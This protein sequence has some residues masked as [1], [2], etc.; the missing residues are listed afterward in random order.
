MNSL[1]K[2]LGKK[3]LNKN[4]EFCNALIS[5]NR[6]NSS[7]SIENFDKTKNQ[8]SKLIVAPRGNLLSKL[9]SKLETPPMKEDEYIREKLKSRSQSQ[10]SIQSNNNLNYLNRLNSK[11]ENDKSINLESIDF[12][13]NYNSLSNKKK[14]VSSY[15][16]D[17]NKNEE[18][19][20]IDLKS[21]LDNYEPKSKNENNYRSKEQIKNRNFINDTQKNQFQGKLSD[22]QCKSENQTDEEIEIIETS[23]F[24]N[25]INIIKKGFPN[26][27][28]KED[29][30]KNSFENHKNVEAINLKTSGKNI[31]SNFG[32]FISFKD[33]F[34]EDDF[35]LENDISNEEKKITLTQSELKRIKITMLKIGSKISLL[36]NKLELRYIKNSLE[37]FKKNVF[38]D[39]NSKIK[40]FTD[41]N[42]IT[43][44]LILMNKKFIKDQ[45][46]YCNSKDKSQDNQNINNSNSKNLNSE[47]ISRNIP[48]DNKS[49]NDF[50]KIDQIP[51][52]YENENFIT[53]ENMGNDQIKNTYLNSFDKR[54]QNEYITSYSNTNP[55]DYESNIQNTVESKDTNLKN[56]NKKESNKNNEKILIQDQTNCSNIMNKNVKISDGD[57][58]NDPE[59]LKFVISELNNAMDRLLAKINH[60]NNQIA[61]KERIIEYQKRNLLVL[62]ERN[63]LQDEIKFEL[64]VLNRN[65]K[66]LDNPIYLTNTNFENNLRLINDRYKN[67]NLKI[68]IVYV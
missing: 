64:E 52:D 48:F 42:S 27:E 35:N 67:L 12:K 8:S 66:N 20:S 21:N 32:N 33:E 53:E 24:K 39:S 46:I 34:N 15:L 61:N 2:S 19:F 55:S 30:K 14:P 54:Q 45:K 10:S 60:L 3:N 28:N 23:N 16:N 47:S 31:E 43:N 44:D 4:L 5:K 7:H 50:Y 17:N 38:Q 6:T 49:I 56:L 65:V 29:K 58:N 40:A 26:F 51:S 18:E 25:K 36:I 11:N 13:D 37:I 1:S 59:F 22:N 63:L 57:R 9:L 62:N 68:E 41:K